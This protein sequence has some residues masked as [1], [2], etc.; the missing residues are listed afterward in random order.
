[1]S[2][3]IIILTIAILYA[4]VVAGQST[5]TLMGSRAFGLGRT[6]SCLNDEWSILNNVGG[7]ANIEQP[8]AAF[9]QEINPSLVSFS[10]TAA[11][12]AFPISYGVTGLSLF[13]LGDDLYSEQIISFG[14]ANTFGI[15]SIGVKLNYV[16]YRVD[17]FG[18]K[19][20]LT[21]NAGGITKLTKK[22]M[23]GTYITN[24]NQPKLSNTDREHLPTI[25][26]AG[27]GIKASETIFITTE[28]EKDLDFDPTWKTGME[29][30]F[31]KKFKARTGFNIN[32]NAFF[33]GCGFISI[34]LKLD[35]AF[36]Y[37]PSLGNSH[38]VSIG[39]SFKR[40][41]E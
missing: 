5:T 7:L 8:M 24:I 14:F 18:R 21:I 22:I 13:R 16:Q 2:K 6:S 20:M 23:I 4:I 33:A 17:G 1:L 15:T 31:N 19:G 40:R 25:V 27:L 26:T 28:I 10:R 12:I 39:Y 38:H 32:P 35:Y 11:T 30:S 41:K 29:Y 34:K 37:S 9:A 3:F 36:Q